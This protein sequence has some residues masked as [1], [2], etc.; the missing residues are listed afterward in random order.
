MA[1]NA[2]KLNDAAQVF[3]TTMEERGTPVKT[4]DGV[5]HYYKDGYWS[6]G[7]EKQRYYGPVLL[8]KA[9][10]ASGVAW[11]EK[12][13]PL[14]ETVRAMATPEE[15][16]TTDKDRLLACKNGMLDPISGEMYEH[17]PDYYCTRFVDVTHQSKAKCP[18]W[19]AALD[20]M[21]E[22]KD[23]AT[24]QEIAAVI[25]E[26]FGLGIVG[27]HPSL[28]RSLRR[29]L[30][31]AGAS[32]T[33]K[34]SVASVFAEFFGTT[35]VCVSSV[36]EINTKFGAAQL[37][38]T[39]AWI[40]NEAIDSRGKTS[41]AR[42]K[43]ILNNEPIT[44]EPKYLGAFPF[45]FTGPAMY[46]TNT[47]LKA[48]EDSDAIFKRILA[49]TFNRVFTSKDEKSTLGK[50]GSLVNKLKGIDEM[51]G[52]LNWSLRGYERALEQGDFT[53]CKE[54]TDLRTES[55]RQSS[56]TFDFLFQCTEYKK[57]VVNT[58]R[59][60]SVAAS[61]YARDEH[62][63]AE[64]KS[65]A[66]R[67][68]ADMIK[69]MHPLVQTGEKATLAGKQSTIYAGLQ[70]NERGLRVVEAAKERGGFDPGERVPVNERR[71]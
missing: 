55:M 63:I 23:E 34:S 54:I 40:A 59:V 1:N 42:L 70:L 64:S 14:W 62:G 46:T 2:D 60:I 68:V 24:R 28:P 18:E 44:V 53:P 25:Q 31:L 30:M 27:R 66:R 56:P 11:G 19:E 67:S 5:L 71:V 3:L 9:A 16:I 69:S 22:D 20:R 10:D 38:G 26:W 12:Q 45:V 33:G 50:Y 32:G 29:A 58:S 8:K 52:V 6:T 43:K 13:K 15:E 48:N 57:G 17:S 36:E 37:L 51:P 65:A 41:V 21:L 4:L 7:L 47:L 39:L 35:R 61:Q 49:M